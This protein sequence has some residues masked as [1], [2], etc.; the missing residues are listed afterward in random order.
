[1]EALRK[2]QSLLSAPE[3]REIET[4]E[5]MESL[6]AFLTVLNAIAF[7]LLIHL[8]IAGNFDSI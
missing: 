7:L 8:R 6:K 4:A 3:S 1:M 2:L 5:A